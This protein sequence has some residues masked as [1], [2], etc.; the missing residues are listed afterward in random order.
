MVHNG[1]VTVPTILASGS[2]IK[3]L[4]KVLFIMPMVT[5]TKV[6]GKMI[7]PM[8]LENISIQTVSFTKDS[9]K[10]IS[11]TATESNNG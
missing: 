9:G 10:T 5:Y 7:N 4:E 3:R 1:G 6:N 8:G 2:S 11:K